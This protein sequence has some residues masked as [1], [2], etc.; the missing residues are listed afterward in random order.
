MKG[1]LGGGRLS[2]GTLRFKTKILVLFESKFV[3]GYW[4]FL[5][6]RCV[7]L[8]WLLNLVTYLPNL[9]LLLLR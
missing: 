4:F 8:G 1:W 5:L 3:P 6:L 9:L 7:I 2:R